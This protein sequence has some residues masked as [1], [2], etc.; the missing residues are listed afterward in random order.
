MGLSILLGTGVQLVAD[1]FAEET[2]LDAKRNNI[3]MHVLG[4][5]G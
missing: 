4:R 2:K 5:G 3:F 1:M